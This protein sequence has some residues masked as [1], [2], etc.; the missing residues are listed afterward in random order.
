[1]P[2]S[3]TRGKHTEE[4]WTKWWQFLKRKIGEVPNCIARR[5]I[6]LRG[7]IVREIIRDLYQANVVIAD[8]T[9]GN[10]NVYWELG[11]RQSFKH[12]TITIAETRK[13][14]ASDMG[15]KGVLRYYPKNTLKNE[16]F[17]QT[18][19]EAIL[20]CIENPDSPDSQVLETISGRGSLYKIIKRDEFLRRTEALISE[21]I[22]NNNKILNIYKSINRNKEER[23]KEKDEEKNISFPADLLIC[24]AFSTLL[25]ERYLE[26]DADFY[27][28][29]LKYI[30]LIHSIN[31]RNE[32]WPGSPLNNEK[33]F[34]GNKGNVDNVFTLTNGL[35]ELAYLKMRMT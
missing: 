23:K 4:Y 9:D 26:E 2:F 10:S 7:D 31:T 21:L 15:M 14:V 24:Y 35:I 32:A 6:A 22:F 17:V 27:I 1:M 25:S 18:L 11:V 5:S 3:K 19:K 12:G 16:E 28:N 20:D 29:M 8:L 13:H 34:E 30:A 33:W